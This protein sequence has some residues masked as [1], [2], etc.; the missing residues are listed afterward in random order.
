MDEFLK[1]RYMN[2]VFAME[3]FMSAT[4]KERLRGYYEEG[5]KGS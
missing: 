2:H 3:E 1:E 4:L 5:R